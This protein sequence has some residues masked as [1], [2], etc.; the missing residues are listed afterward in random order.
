MYVLYY[1]CIYA[2][3]YNKYI[4]IPIPLHILIYITG[5]VVYDSKEGVLV[6]PKLRA[7]YLDGNLD[8]GHHI[9]S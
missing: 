4:D 9:L 1:T 7:G 8:L 3:M 6:V 5:G 2:S